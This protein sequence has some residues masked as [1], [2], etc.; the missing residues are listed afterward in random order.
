VEGSI[1]RS[2]DTIRIT[3]QLIDA[4]ADR[5][6][7]ANEY[8]S[9]PSDVLRLQQKVAYDIASQ[10]S[11]QISPQRRQHSAPARA[12]NPKAHDLYLRARQYA[13]QWNEPA[14]FKAMDL[15]QQAIALQP[16]YAAAY[17]GLAD[18]HSMFGTVGAGESE[19]EWPHVRESALKAL[20][21][22]DS[23]PRA[24]QLLAWV[25][26]IYDWDTVGAE[27]EF[28]KALNTDRNDAPTH[29]AYAIFLGQIGRV[30]EGL[31]EAQI[32]EELDPLS[33][34]VSGAKELMFMIAK[35]Y[36]NVFKQA[37]RTRELLPDSFPTT[38]HVGETYEILGRYEE[39][40]HEFETH[41]MPGYF[42]QQEATAFANKLR[43][44]LRRQGPK[45][46]WGVILR[47]R[48]ATQAD[49]HCLLNTAS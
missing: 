19:G 36:D 15:Y 32:A 5:H 29:V 35:Q 14:M 31:A 49:D 24:H 45:G 47:D 30:E 46:Y 44:G 42:T 26:H 17:I 25:K 48:L 41:P 27:E 21:L 10:V 20:S 18:A 8:E 7:W 40:I 39:A 16:D 38:L 11:A 4:K 28:R 34:R 2:A 23:V 12:V 6:L 43:S 13:E 22:D 3:A 33:G 9:S 1:A 37:N